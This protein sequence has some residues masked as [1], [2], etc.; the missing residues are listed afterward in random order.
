MNDA[1]KTAADTEQEGGL[2]VFGS[3]RLMSHGIGDRQG[4]GT[5]IAQ[6]LEGGEVFFGIQPDR[7]EY[8]DRRVWIP[9]RYS[10]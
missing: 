7:F 8:R 2:A 5:A 4:Y 3:T 1:G 9:G 10:Y 6:S